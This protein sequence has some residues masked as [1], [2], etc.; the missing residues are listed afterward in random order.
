MAGALYRL[1]YAGLT[2][3]G[4]VVYIGT[5]GVTGM[6]TA[7]S[8]F[9]G[10]IAISDRARGSVILTV[11]APGTLATGRSVQPGDTVTFNVDAPP[12]FTN[13]QDVPVTIDGALVNVRFTKIQDIPIPGSLD[14]S[15][16]ANTALFTAAGLA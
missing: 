9:S 7:G 3:G 2:T 12:D 11:K 16:P 6:D 14:G 15:N 1:D 5:D 10:G 13:G 8:I 4:G